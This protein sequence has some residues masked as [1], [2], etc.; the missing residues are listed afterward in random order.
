MGGRA[1]RAAL[2]ALAVLVLVAVVAVA[3]TGSVPG[4]SGESRAPSDALLDTLFT[5]W[6]LAVVAGGVLLVCGLL[7]RQAIAKQIARS[8]YPRFTLLSWLVFAGLLAVSV[9]LFENWRPEG[10]NPVEEEGVFGSPGEPPPTMPDDEVLR[11]YHPSLS[12]IPIVVVSGLVVAAAIAYVVAAR[13]TRPARGPEADLAEELAAALDDALDDLRAETDPRLAII[14]AYARLERVLAASGVARL[15]AET[16]D[17]YLV[18][19]L[20][21]LELT[22]EAIGRL[23]ELFAQAKFSNHAVDS[24]MKES[25]IAALEHVRDELQALRD[26]PLVSASSVRRAV[27]S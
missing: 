8:R 1:G 10:F 23:T 27:T 9:W 6:I 13:R 2:P 22:P 4:G 21:S 5:L 24:A 18:R 19:V 26:A 12:W 3:A 16:A 14:A 25:A 11:Q 7:Q 17:E 15:G 20:R